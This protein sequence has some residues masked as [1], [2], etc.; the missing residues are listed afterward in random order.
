MFKSIGAIL[1]PWFLIAVVLQSC[2]AVQPE[3]VSPP[4]DAKYARQGVK[5]AGLLGTVPTTCAE[6][7]AVYLG[8]V[9]VADGPAGISVVNA[10]DPAKPAV[11]RTISTTFA[12]RLYIHENY[13][14][15]CDGP[16]GIRVYS[17]AK[18]SEPALTYFCPTTWASGIAF[19]NGYM[20]LGDYYDGVKIF[21]LSDPAQ[22]VLLAANIPSR[23]RDVYIDGTTLAVADSAF[24]LVTYILNAPTQA[25]WTYIDS[26]RFANFEDVVMYNGYSIIARNDESSSIAVFRTLDPMHVELA[27]ELH[28]TRFISGITRF[29]KVLFAACGEEGVLAFDLTDMTDIRLLWV[30]NTAGFAQRA[31]TSGNILYIADMSGLCIYDITGMGGDWS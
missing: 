23:A 15:L 19:N 6:D 13:L 7:I 8:Y 24:G 22:P 10:K 18:P 28:P 1:A 2:N 14:Y 29:G 4:P 5:T 27:D 31:K 3:R 30:V 17:L 26:S 25:L 21:L 11:I 9:Y 20:Y 12:Y 16:A